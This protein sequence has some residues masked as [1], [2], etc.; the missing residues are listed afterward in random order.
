MFQVNATY[1]PG[2]RLKGIFETAEGCIT[3]KDCVLRHP[4]V[5]FLSSVVIYLT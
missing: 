4:R 2:D 3:R 1:K 5:L